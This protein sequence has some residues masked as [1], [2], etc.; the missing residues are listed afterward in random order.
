MTKHH[1]TVNAVQI[2]FQSN[3]NQNLK[4]IS[5]FNFDKFDKMFLEYM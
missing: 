4:Q 2:E 3:S 1:K 5:F